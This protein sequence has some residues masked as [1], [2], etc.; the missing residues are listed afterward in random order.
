MKKAYCC[1][2]DL[3][4]QAASGLEQIRIRFKPGLKIN[5]EG[6]ILY[7]RDNEVAQRHAAPINFIIL[8]T[9]GP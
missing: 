3:A 6:P 1:V 4:L 9:H 2:S 7:R 5:N 8:G